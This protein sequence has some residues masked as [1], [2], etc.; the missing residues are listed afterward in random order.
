MIYDNV[1]QRRDDMASFLGDK[2]SSYRMAQVTKVIDGR[3]I[4]RF[5]G[6]SKDSSKRYKYLSSYKPEAGDYV[7]LASLARTYVIL[8][9]VV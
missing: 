9:K 3:P 8:G 5:N 6:E 2:G 4:L 1:S 7:L